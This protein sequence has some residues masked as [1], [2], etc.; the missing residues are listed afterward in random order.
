MKE[1]TKLMFWA[2]IP[3]MLGMITVRLARGT[4]GADWEWAIGPVF[5][6]LFILAQIAVERERQ[7]DPLIL[8]LACVISGIGLV[9]IYSINPGLAGRQ[10][11]WIFLGVAILVWGVVGT[12]DYLRLQNYGYVWAVLGVLLLVLTLL[13]GKEV[14]GARAWLAIGPL[15]FQPSEV[16]KVLLIL[17]LAGYLK[18]GQEILGGAGRA[19]WGVSLPAM[20]YLGPL[21]LMWGVLLVLL[22][23]QRDLGQAFL[24]FGILLGMVFLVSGRTSYVLG[25]GLALIAAG[26]LTYNIFPHVRARVDVWLHP[27]QDPSGRGYQ[28]VQALYAIASGGLFGTGAGF[29]YPELVP[30]C[31]TDF[32]FA[33]VFEEMGLFGA[34]FVVGSY[35]LL[36]YRGFK[37]ARDAPGDFGKLVAGGISILL[38]LQTFTI[39]GG[40]TK[41][42]PLTGVTL[43][44][45]SYGGT[46]IITSFAGLALLVK[47]SERE[48]VFEWNAT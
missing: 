8:P 5:A 17:F 41:L 3:V 27:W 36:V 39:I 22:I 46:S 26:L 43:P 20:L 4:T 34:L 18:D 38:G 10:L 13:F 37:I 23:L 25:G 31:E 32:I 14:G 42:L 6:L 47:I 30:A 9:E 21:L 24:F 11:F 1:G 45:M 16:A 7:A 29:G 40:V 19:F 35:L 12:F 33:A 28:I 48:R 44:L 15:S 2:V